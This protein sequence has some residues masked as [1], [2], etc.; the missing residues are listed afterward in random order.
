ML[1]NHHQQIHYDHHIF[2]YTKRISP[3]YWRRSNIWNWSWLQ[4]RHN[5]SKNNFWSNWS[6]KKYKSS[7][8]D[9]TW[10]RR[11]LISLIILTWTH[12]S[13]GS[14]GE[15][16]QDYSMTKVRRLL[17]HYRHPDAHSVNGKGNMFF[18]WGGH[19]GFCLYFI[20]WLGKP[21]QPLPPN[22]DE[23]YADSEWTKK[24]FK[25]IITWLCLKSN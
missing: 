18:F 15:Q 13:T 23:V 1:P 25:K 10:W 6:T 20:F 5:R 11:R 8:A 7:G 22:A 19:G 12:I 3:S 9:N 17:N 14:G 21:F 2:M 16:R 24:S 4:R